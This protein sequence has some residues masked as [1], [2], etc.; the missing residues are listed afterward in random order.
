MKKLEAE[1]Q[2]LES[3]SNY[4]ILIGVVQKDTTR[5]TRGLE[6]EVLKKIASRIKSGEITLNDLHEKWRLR[7]VELL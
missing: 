2:L 5:N 1:K 3:L 4:T 6:T 7:V